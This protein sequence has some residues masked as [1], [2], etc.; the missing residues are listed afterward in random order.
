[1]PPRT[2]SALTETTQKVLQCQAALQEALRVLDGGGIEAALGGFTDALASSS[3]ETRALLTASGELARLTHEVIASQA[4]LQSA[5]Q[6]LADADFAATLRDFRE[7][8]AGLAP[9]LAG[10]QRPFVLQAVPMAREN[11]AAA[12]DASTAGSGR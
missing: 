11:A 4:A 10:F 6:Q 2:L 3:A 12:S 7:S 8:L 5:T 9:V 1:M